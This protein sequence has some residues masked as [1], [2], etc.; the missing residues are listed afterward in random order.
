VQKYGKDW[1][2]VAVMFLNPTNEQCC[3]RWTHILN[4]NLNL[5]MGKS[6]VEEDTKLTEAVTKYG[7]DWVAFSALVPGRMNEKIAKDG[8]SSCTLALTTG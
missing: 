8:A 7:N 1:V 6:T 3:K 4:P 5:T 2:A